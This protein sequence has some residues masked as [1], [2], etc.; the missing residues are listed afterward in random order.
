MGCTRHAV[1]HVACL[2]C[3]AAIGA[4]RPTVFAE[5]AAAELGSGTATCPGCGDLLAAPPDACPRCSRPGPR[6]APVADLADLTLR[7]L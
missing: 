6:F 5:L 4:L 7:E 2:H 1:A 3:R